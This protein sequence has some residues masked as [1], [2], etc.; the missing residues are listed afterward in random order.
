MYIAAIKTS[1]RLCLGLCL[2]LSTGCT[3]L[4]S[5]QAQDLWQSR[6]KP[7]STIEKPLVGVLVSDPKL[8]RKAEADWVLDLR[9][10]DIAAAPAYAPLAELSAINPASLQR[11]HEKHAMDSLLT[12]SLSLDRAA[13]ETRHN[14]LAEHLDYRLNLAFDAFVSQVELAAVSVSAY[15]LVTNE[16]LWQAVYYV[17]VKEGQIDW[18]LV[19]R[20]ANQDMAAAGLQKP[21][22]PEV[23]EAPAKS[24]GQPAEKPAR[25]T[26]APH[27]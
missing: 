26:G 8:R 15:S 18:S 21:P 13:A 16:L 3:Y 12:A 19:A 22:E 25:Q 9:Q 5:L 11:L 27:K 14:T 1:I 20:S 6:G 23:E 4:Q 17:P 24:S 2:I 7:L 10:R